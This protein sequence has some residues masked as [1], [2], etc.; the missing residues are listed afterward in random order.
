[1][2]RPNGFMELIPVGLAVI[3]GLAGAIEPARS[4]GPAKVP[5]GSQ[6]TFT[7][8]IA[9]ILQR[10]CQTCH[11]PESMAPMSLLSYKEVRPWARSIKSKVAQ[12]EMPPWFIDKTVGVR[13]F[14]DDVSLS[15][16][17]IATIVSWVDAGAPEGNPA[18]MPPPRKFLDDDQ[19][20]I[21]KPDLIISMPV[22]FTVKA[23]G[24]DWWGNFETDSGLTEDR[25]I[26]AVETIPGPGGG[27]RV[28]H[29][30]V[31]SMIGEDGFSEGGLLN[32]YAVGKNGDIYPDGSG[33]LMKAGTRIR[34]NMHYHTVGTEITDQ[35][36]VGVVFYPKGYM[37]HHVVT[38]V[39]AESKD[40]DIPPGE[41]NV[42][43]EAYYRLTKPARLTAFQP[44]M[45]NR[46]KAQCIEAIY[47]DLRVEQLSCVNHYNFGW[48][49][50]YNYADDVAP[51]LPAG[52]II[53]VT[54]W[55]DN[56]AKNPWNP[57]PKAWVGFGERT[58]EDMSRAWL[59]F[60]YMSE[61]EF[62]AEVAA[63]KTKLYSMVK[64]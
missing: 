59:S 49:I 43:S 54:S 11:R 35:T 63:R 56:S 41:E 20:H 60:Y 19:W 61:D 24:P 7:K 12:R 27:H 57:D 36:R 48:Q 29:H 6:V 9:P 51:L 34:F 1:M 10:S 39:A 2:S 13:D 15:D 26:K 64:P 45:H 4:Q 38:S 18:N 58:T 47:P 25:Y 37:P 53:H 16:Q 42:R 30:A 31:A 21:G 8:D 46:G 22:S 52:T 55:H 5:A 3:V 44:H 62:R 28:V 23:R 50:A 17:E 40:L 14:K 33:K 32:E